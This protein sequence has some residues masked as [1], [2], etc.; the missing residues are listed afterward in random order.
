[1][2]EKY[3]LWNEMIRMQALAVYRY[4]KY[5]PGIRLDIL[6]KSTENCSQ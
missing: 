2:R 5:D 3:V 1:M 6:K 4:F